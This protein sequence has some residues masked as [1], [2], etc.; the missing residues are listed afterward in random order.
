MICI[1]REN[2]PRACSYL[3]CILLEVLVSTYPPRLGL[4]KDQT[5]L[6]LT[7]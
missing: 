6:K 4:L 7:L 2:H 5:N 1:S 3:T